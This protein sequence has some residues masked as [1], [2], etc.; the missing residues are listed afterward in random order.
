MNEDSNNRMH[1]TPGATRTSL[2]L[3]PKVSILIIVPMLL[4]LALSTILGYVQ[5]RDRALSSMSLIASQTGQVIEHALEQ[6]M[7]KSDFE[8]I[9]LAFDTIGQDSRIRTLYLMDTDGRVVVAPDGEGVGNRLD[10][11][12]ETCQPC[13]RL[14]AT[15][16]P[17][18]IVVEADDG[19]PFFRSMN[20]IENQPECTRCHDPDKPL[21]GLLLTDL[22]IA[23]VEAALASDLRS[24]LAWSAGTV[25][26]TGIL[27][28]LA[29]NRWVLVRLRRLSGALG[30]IAREG[31]STKLPEQ[32]ADE[33]GHLSAAFN[34]M[35][36]RIQKRDREN[37]ALS[38]ALQAQAEERGQLLERLIQAQEEERKRVARELHDDLGQGL[39]SI[40]LTIEVAQGEL[41]SKP[42]AAGEHL[43]Q[44]RRLTADVIDRMY[45]LI[46]GLRPSVLDDLGLIPA[47]RAHLQ[48]ALEPEGISFE[49]DEI[50]LKD[51][52]PA[53][54]ETALFR[55]VQEAITN[56]VRHSRATHVSLQIAQQGED[57]R[58]EIADN[59]MGFNLGAYRSA[60]GDSHGFGL[61]GM[62]E[63]V[64]H[65]AGD[66]RIESHPGGG[67]RIR[68]RI[69]TKE[70]RR[71]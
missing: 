5:Q 41:R 32:P 6:E 9:Q 65:L 23:P 13:H 57:V 55:I 15:E 1:G 20:P 33:I 50:S 22:S 10:Y 54:I 40:A 42:G 44:A 12:D 49:L 4:I 58:A 34:S 47:L 59:G 17:S 39:T 21:N 53:A 24:N 63:R 19:E 14:P 7:L 61:L 25:I 29:V 31:L 16:R 27:A 64:S 18:G 68:V 30:D 11:R 51:R 62:R 2:N 56:I 43:K 52:L 60:H 46:L 28:N 8:G 67:T 48:T 66:L 36:K 37:K 45:N 69:P 38:E 70:I 26:V 35:A 3:Q 71:A